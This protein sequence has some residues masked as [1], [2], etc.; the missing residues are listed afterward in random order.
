MTNRERYITKRNEYD[1]M[2]TIEKKIPLDMCV[3][4]VISG[5][6]PD[7]RHGL[8]WYGGW[9]GKCDDCIQKFLNEEYAGK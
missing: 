5:E 2:K 9:N 8:C 4:E 3:I 7:P 6:H 1:M